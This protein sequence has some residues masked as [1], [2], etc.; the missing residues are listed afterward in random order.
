ML[1]GKEMGAKCIILEG[2]ANQ[3][4]QAV[5]FGQPC[6]SIY[7][8]LIEDIQEGMVDFRDSSF[9]FTP[10][11]GNFV[12]YGLAKEAI[13]HVVDVTWRNEILPCIYDIIKREEFSPPL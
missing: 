1:L 12:A 7:G 8:H 11:D 4:V 13:K 5:N 3:I 2:D 9:T 10:C 6:N